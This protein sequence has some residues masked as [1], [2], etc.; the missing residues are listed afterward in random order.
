MGR[1]IPVVASAC[2]TTVSEFEEGESGLS[3]RPGDVES[4][5][6]QLLKL[7]SDEVANK[8]SDSTYRKF[9]DN[10]PTLGNHIDQLLGT[11]QTILSSS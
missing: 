5:S 9:W 4:L 3:F 11:Y 10:P 6:E 8:M 2:T 7:Q 1:G